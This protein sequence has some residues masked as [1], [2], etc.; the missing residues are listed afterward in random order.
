[1]EHLKICERRLR[2]VEIIEFIKVKFLQ[3]EEVLLTIGSL[4][5]GGFNDQSDIDIICITD[6]HERVL[7]ISNC[8]GLDL[9]NYTMKNYN[10]Y[11][12]GE[13]SLINVRCRIDN[14][15]ISCLVMDIALIEFIVKNP[16]E[17][18]FQIRN[19]IPNKD[20]LVYDYLKQRHIFQRKQIKID[21]SIYI[22]NYINFVN[23]NGI[24]GHGSLI[25]KL[26]S[27]PVIQCTNK[28]YSLYITFLI[29]L[30][31]IYNIVRKNF[32]LSKQNNADCFFSW[33]L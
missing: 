9:S 7:Q 24:N 33:T 27:K 2:A 15:D 32:E 6:T 12:K 25:N 8:L 31:S 16:T 5:H 4:A 21:E 28:T 20:T 23:F 17:E 19:Y 22:S 30:N 10:S 18:L 29:Y 13:Y 1:M 14:F 26:T 3:P 11:S